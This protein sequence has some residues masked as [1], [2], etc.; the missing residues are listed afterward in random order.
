MGNKKI[1][2]LALLISV[3]LV[4]SGVWAYDFDDLRTDLGG[5]KDRT[6]TTLKSYD[7]GT[8]TRLAT[9]AVTYTANPVSLPIAVASKIDIRPLVAT[10]Q[11]KISSTVRAGISDFTNR[12]NAYNPFSGNF[13]TNAFTKVA[14]NTFSAFFPT[15]AISLNAVRRI[16]L[17]SAMQDIGA[18]NPLNSF[19]IK[20]IFELANK[21]SLASPILLPIYIPKS[22]NL[23]HLSNTV[24]TGLGE[25]L[26]GL[27]IPS[28][29]GKLE[30]VPIAHLK[31]LSIATNY[32]LRGLTPTSAIKNLL[33][34][35]LYNGKPVMSRIDE[36]I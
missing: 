36:K 22:I 28:F 27:N 7:F 12:L 18:F 15:T 34:N 2:I 20:P 32:P 25:K 35:T 16:D 24:L 26:S 33:N 14:S 5:F 6:F 3:L 9:R 1:L 8:A 17:N 19:N 4:H 10:A 13:N 21:V 31:N 23:S 29:P 11:D 30:L